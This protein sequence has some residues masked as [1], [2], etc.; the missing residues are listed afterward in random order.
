MLLRRCPAT[1]LFIGSSKNIQEGSSALSSPK[2][3]NAENSGNL[4][5]KSSVE[6]FSNS[7]KKRQLPI[8]ST[9]INIGEKGTI[10]RHEPV[11]DVDL[12][13]PLS[14][15]QQVPPREESSRKQLVARKDRNLEERKEKIPKQHH[16]AIS[17]LT[18]NSKSPSKNNVIR[19]TEQVIQ[20]WQKDSNLSHDIPLEEAR[21]LIVDDSDYED[22]SQNQDV[23]KH[24]FLRRK[25]K[26]MPPQKLDWSKV[27]LLNISSLISIII[28]YLY[29]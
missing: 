24:P 28:M 16:I 5:L 3:I 21:S 11:P 10:G 23:P 25:S 12:K 2:L 4:F 26:A 7:Q 9:N 15:S 27:L 1:P 18:I 19:K 20:L 14:S 29:G 6:N 8:Q 22:M 13:A 17:P